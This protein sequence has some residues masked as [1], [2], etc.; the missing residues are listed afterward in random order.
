MALAV[1]CSRLSRLKPNL[2]F[3]GFIVDHKARQNS[4]EEANVVASRLRHLGESLGFSAA[5]VPI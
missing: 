2:Q 4:D 5:C 1:L 3:T